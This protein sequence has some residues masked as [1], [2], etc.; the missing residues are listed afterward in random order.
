MPFNSNIARRISRVHADGLACPCLVELPVGLF[1]F[2]LAEM[3]LS[4]VRCSTS[5]R[6]KSITMMWFV[7]SFHSML[8]GIRSLCSTR[9]L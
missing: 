6:S 3:T 5:A 7:S 2:R 1:L 9:C 4:T 8:R